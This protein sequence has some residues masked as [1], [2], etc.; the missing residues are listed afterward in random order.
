MAKLLSLP[1]LR[2]AFLLR[3]ILVWVAVRVALAFGGAGDPELGTELL[4]VFL[5]PGIVLLDARRRAE[6]ILLGN[7]GIPSWAI[8]QVALPLVALLEAL[9]P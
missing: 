3:A 2:N 1:P 5:V 4:V 9:V 6:D 7:L 8:A